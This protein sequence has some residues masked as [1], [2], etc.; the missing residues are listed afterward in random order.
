MV[1]WP[2]MSGGNIRRIV[3]YS[4]NA[5]AII[6]WRRSSR[7]NCDADEIRDRKALMAR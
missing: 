2:P 6:R 1:I 4:R 3:P 5:W 7:L